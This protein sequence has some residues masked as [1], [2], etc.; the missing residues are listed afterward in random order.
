MKM[1]ATIFLPQ[2]KSSFKK[3]VI[4]KTINSLLFSK[5]QMS[6]LIIVI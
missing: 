1:Y 2:L 5:C 6:K 3:E 4:V